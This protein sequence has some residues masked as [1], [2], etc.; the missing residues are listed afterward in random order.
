[1]PTT[2][3]RDRTTRPEHRPVRD[4]LNAVR[5]LGRR[6]AGRHLHRPVVVLEQQLAHR[7]YSLRDLLDESL[8]GG[9]R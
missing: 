5:H 4:A 6:P 1:M 7:D 9:A 8:T 2:P 3:L